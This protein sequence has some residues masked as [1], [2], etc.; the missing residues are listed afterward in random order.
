M[1]IMYFFTLYE[2]RSSVDVLI[3]VYSEN[4]LLLFFLIIITILLN[5]CIYLVC[6]V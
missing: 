4:L 2:S 1:S 3:I 6:T 5:E